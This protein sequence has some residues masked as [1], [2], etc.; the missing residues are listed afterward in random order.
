MPGSPLS[1][2]TNAAISGHVFGGQQAVTS[3]HIYLLAVSTGGYSTASSSLLITSTNGTDSIGGY[4]LTDASGNFNITG[5]YSCTTGQQ[6][7]LLATQG[8]PGWSAAPMRPR[9]A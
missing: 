3:A 5:D 4:V 8:N 6:M 1:T 7:Y 2:P 9:S